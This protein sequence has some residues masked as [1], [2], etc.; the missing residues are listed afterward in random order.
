MP[1]L[2]RAQQMDS[3]FP[4][5]KNMKISGCPEQ[6]SFLE[7]G[8]PLS[9][10]S[11]RISFCDELEAFDDECFG[12]LSCLKE[13]EIHNCAQFM[14]FPITEKPDM[15]LSSKFKDHIKKKEVKEYGSTGTSRSIRFG[16]ANNNIFWE[17]EVVKDGKVSDITTTQ[18]R[19]GQDI[20]GIPWDKFNK[21]REQYRQRRLEVYKNYENIPFSGERV[22]NDSKITEKGLIYYEF[23]RNAPLVKPNILHFQLRNLVWATSKCDVYLNQSKSIVHW[24]SLTSSRSEVLNLSRHVA[25]SE[26]HPGSLL[27]G[28]KKTFISTIAVKD[29]LLVVGGYQGELICKS[30]DWPGVSYCYKTTYDNNAITNSV[31]I[32]ASPS[33][34]VHFLAS[35]NDCGIRE[36]NMQRFQLSKHLRFSWPV[37]HSSLSPDSKLLVVVGD[38]PNGLMVDPQ[39]GKTVAEFSEHKD[40]SFA[41]SW[42][43]NGVIFATGNQDKTC[44]V[45]DIRNLSKSVAILSG[46]LAAIRSIR[47]TSDGCYM[48]TAEDADF[49][50]IYDVKSGFEKE[51]EIDFFGE[52]SGISFS[53]EAE[54]LFIGVSD[55]DYGGILEYGRHI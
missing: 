17:E 44:R 31:E 34:V 16:P 35:S 13:L 19:G 49:V 47:F 32:Y 38:N 9:L 39:T 7:G 24:S 41:S 14:N 37:N 25:P 52:I 23:K 3:A 10:S 26:K 4:C 21:N 27:E 40:Y 2:P 12:V 20:L 54:S 51:Q 48:A 36:F 18:A 6:K 8:L 46:N 45:W 22:R 1:L 5:V 11:L 15:M 53:S 33:G 42:H 50:H 28:F 29:K 43:P 30:L 55:R